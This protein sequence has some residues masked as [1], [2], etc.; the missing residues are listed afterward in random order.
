[1]H[2]RKPVVSGLWH[3]RDYAKQK[4]AAIQAV[5]MDDTLAEGASNEPVPNL[6]LQHP[7]KNDLEQ[8][9]ITRQKE[10]QESCC[11]HFHKIYHSSQESKNAG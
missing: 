9:C 8:R 6:C 11:N 4:S 2:G 1:M 7:A 5:Q 10:Q 3:V